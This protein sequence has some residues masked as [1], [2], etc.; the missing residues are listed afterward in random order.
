[1]ILL[2]L[3]YFLKT[4][5]WKWKP[6]PTS[7]KAAFQKESSKFCCDQKDETGPIPHTRARLCIAVGVFLFVSGFFSYVMWDAGS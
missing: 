1:M 7:C 5:S 3:K 4:H 2:V 6:S